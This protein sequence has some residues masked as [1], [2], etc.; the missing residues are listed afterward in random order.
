MWTRRDQSIFTANNKLHFVFHI[1]QAYSQVDARE[2]DNDKQGMSFKEVDDKI[3][4][5]H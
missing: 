4:L 2:L 1:V 5:P 3:R